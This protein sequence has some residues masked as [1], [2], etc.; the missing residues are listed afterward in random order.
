MEIKGSAT[1]NKKTCKEIVHAVYPNRTPAVILSSIIFI[2]LFIL[3]I[4]IFFKIDRALS[5]MILM[6][7]VISGVIAYMFI[8]LPSIQYASMGS[9]KDAV[10]NY[11][12][13]D[14]ELHTQMTYVDGRIISTSAVKY[15]IIF[16]VIENSEY[17][18][19]FQNKRSLY[20]VEKNTVNSDELD[21]LIAF[22]KKQCPMKYKK[23]KK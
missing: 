10:C 22:L 11:I 2:L 1:F 9:S 16:K 19:I 5:Y 17:I 4:I 6:F 20:I 13:Y 15:D 23:S 14:D 18:F 7:S 21:E 3:G 12:F 8:K